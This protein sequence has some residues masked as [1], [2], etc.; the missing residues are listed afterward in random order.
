VVAK[1]S[2]KGAPAEQTMKIVESAERVEP[3]EEEEEATE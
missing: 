3:S 2:A 1:R